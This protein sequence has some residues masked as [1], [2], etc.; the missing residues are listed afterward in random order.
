MR[1]ILPLL[2]ACLSS[3]CVAT[4][5]ELY[6]LAAQVETVEKAAQAA[7]EAASQGITAFEGG[8]VGAAALALLHLYRNYTRKH[9]V[10]PK[11][12]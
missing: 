12:K 6:K 8:G 4:S 2:A 1:T 5:G 11:K 3:A 7:T 9:V 10:E